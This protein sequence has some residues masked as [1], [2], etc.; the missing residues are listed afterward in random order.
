MVK[1]LLTYQD[2]VATPD[3]GRRYELVEGEL[4]MSP[5][6]ALWHQ[7]LLHRLMM[8]LL[9]RA[10]AAGY[11]E[12]FIAPVDVIFDAAERNTAQPDAF[13]IRRERR[14]IATTTVVR[15]APDL[16]VEVLSPST[17]AY[18][19]RT[20]RQ[21]YA[22]FQVPYY[23]GVDPEAQAVQCF[24]LVGDDYPPPRLLSG[25]DELTCPLFP[26]ITLP[27]TALF[28]EE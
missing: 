12:G 8:H 25:A 3:D 16:I 2:L 5:A 21:L 19:L 22:R 23:W 26:D 11:G 1:T 24:T 15:G 4:T 18:D 14:Q 7:R 6:P 9:D 28:V 17:R 27:V 13:F 10:E 20:K